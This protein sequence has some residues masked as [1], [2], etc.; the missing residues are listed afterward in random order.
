MILHQIVLKELYSSIM[1][2]TSMAQQSQWQLSSLPLLPPHRFSQVSGLTIQ[3]YRQLCCLLQIAIFFFQKTFPDSFY[4]ADFE[5]LN[6]IFRIPPTYY[7]SL[8]G[9]I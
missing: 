5:I 9:F 2:R 1:W 7:R 3:L 4:F 8:N 6:F